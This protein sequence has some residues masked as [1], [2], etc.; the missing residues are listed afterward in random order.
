MSCHVDA[1]N[2]LAANRKLLAEYGQVVSA[3]VIYDRATDGYVIEAVVA[4]GTLKEGLGVNSKVFVGNTRVYFHEHAVAK[5]EPT[6]VQPTHV[7]EAEQTKGGFRDDPQFKAP[8][9]AKPEAK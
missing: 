8:P 1:V 6:K 3:Q 9:A 2:D 5:T 4:P 7:T